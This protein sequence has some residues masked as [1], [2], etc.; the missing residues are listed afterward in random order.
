MGWLTWYQAA[1][2]KSSGFGHHDASNFHKH[3]PSHGSAVYKAEK[4]Q[5]L[6][7]DLRWDVLSAPGDRATM[8]TAASSVALSFLARLTQ[9]S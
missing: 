1:S 9:K 5:E 6:I 7:A 3:H 2:G 8:R 4:I